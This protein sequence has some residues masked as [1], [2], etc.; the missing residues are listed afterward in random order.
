M[1]IVG[2]P[3]ETKGGEN[4]VAM[5]PDGVKELVGMGLTVCIESGAG[6]RTRALRPTCS[7]RR[8]GP[9]TR[10]GAAVPEELRCEESRRARTRRRTG[11]LPPC[12]ELA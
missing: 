5:T 3:A 12:T 4:R 6:A 2:V 9:G 1:T 8:A 7:L 10:A 11:P